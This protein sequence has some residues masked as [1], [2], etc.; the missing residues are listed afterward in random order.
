MLS[1]PYSPLYLTSGLWI[2]PSSAHLAYMFITVF[3]FNLFYIVILPIGCGV[4]ENKKDVIFIFIFP[5][6]YL[7]Q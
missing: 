7:G 1:P 4:L 6:P 2:T 3:Y 5:V